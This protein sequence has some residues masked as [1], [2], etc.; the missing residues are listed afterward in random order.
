VAQLACG[1]SGRT[2]RQLVEEAGLVAVDGLNIAAVLDRLG[3]EIF[4]RQPNPIA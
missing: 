1:I 3:R 4:L 2:H